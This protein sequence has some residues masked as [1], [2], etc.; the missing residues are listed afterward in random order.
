MTTNEDKYFK[1]NIIILVYIILM[2]FTTA[3]NRFTTASMSN[4]WGTHSTTGIGVN[5]H[6]IK[7]RR[8]GHR[9]YPTLYELHNLNTSS[10]YTYTVTSFLDTDT[11]GTLRYG[12]KYIN[13]LKNTI[14]SN[15]IFDVNQPIYL[16]SNLPDILTSIYFNGLL[17]NDNQ[18]I[19]NLNGYSGLNIKSDHCTISGLSITNSGNSGINI[20]NSYTHIEGCNINN[21]N[22]NGIY[23]TPSSSSNIIGTNVNLD[24]NYISN[25]LWGNRQN[26]IEIDGS[27]S[28]TLHKNYIGT[29]DGVN[30]SP[31]QQNGIYITNGAKNNIIGG[32]IFKNS[33]GD[34]ND[35]TG[36]KNT[37]TPVY[38]IPPLGNLI[39]GNEQNGILIDGSSEYNILYG[40][41]IGTN[42]A[43]ISSL[44]NK[45]DGV[46]MQNSSNN[47]IIGCD[48]YNNP[49]VFYNV[50]SGNGQNGIQIQNSHNCSIQGN[51]IGLNMNNQNVSPN[52]L[53]GLLV[54]GDSTNVV[55]GGVIPLGNGISGNGQNGV[56]V[57]DT[58]INFLSLNTFAGLYAFGGAAPNGQNGILIEGDAIHATIRTSVCSGNI[59]SGIALAG[60]SS[61]T[62]IESVICGP[63]TNYS[64][65]V[66]NKY[67]ITITDGA[68]NNTIDFT[69]NSVIRKSVFSGNI[70]HGIQLL[71]NSKYNSFYSDFV[72]VVY[73]E[74]TDDV[75]VMSN[76]ENGVFLDEETNHNTITNKCI[77]SGNTE[78]GVYFNASTVVENTIIDNFI[79]I[80]TKL[81]DTPNGY[82][83]IGGNINSSNTTSPNT[84]V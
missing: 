52:I 35:P 36:N 41:F 62:N 82:G 42:N 53:D 7:T 5:N 31:N 58:A 77:I 32:K 67:G 70:K 22:D 23:I 65:P 37:T 60:N 66:S 50:I 47:S 1:N 20:Y 8:A 12:I 45:L 27:N 19:I 63:S 14:V 39:S 55:D 24:S 40:N 68:N 38:I 28:N 83:N 72:G 46:L 44:P 3:S 51:F 57:I 15:I 64:T 17:S 2:I 29:I 49:F 81:Q 18:I 21:N 71:G 73:V 4:R 11:I 79:G 56:H 75:V 69:H 76:G 34:I 26:G 25:I 84:L 54:S 30:P 59:E 10:V 16:S 78:W 74:Q 9:H 33:N 61:Y 80:N 43:G 13:N 6:R 48:I